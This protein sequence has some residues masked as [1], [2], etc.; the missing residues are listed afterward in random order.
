MDLNNHLD[1]RLKKMVLILGWMIITAGGLYALKLAGPAIRLVFQVLAPFLL[2]LL[3]AYL[4]YPIIRVAQQRLR[5]GRVG[6]ILT[7][8]LTL[9]VILLVFFGL[10]IPVLYS[11]GA[12]LVTVIE[13]VGPEVL[14]AAEKAVPALDLESKWKSLLE[15][16]RAMD[17][18]FAA[19]AERSAASMP[20]LTNQGMQAAEQVGAFL[21]GAVAAF[22]TL[23]LVIVI[24]FY[25]LAEFEA[26]P[27]I[28][29]LLTP[30]R[31]EE[32]IM[33]ILGKLDNA[34]A[35]FLRGQ[36]I[37]CS[38]IALS[39][40][41]GLALIGMRQY[42]VLVG[43]VAG[44]ANIIP[45]LGPVMGATPGVI[46]ALLSPGHVTWTSRLVHAGLVVVLFAI[47]QMLDGFVFQPKIVG[48]SSNLH[49]LLV[50]FA[51]LAG[52]QFGLGGMIL[53]VPLACVGRVLVLELWWKP[54]MEKREALLRQ[55]P[56]GDRKEAT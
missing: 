1:R 38:L 23:S 37:V 13:R 35:G 19:L 12:R 20:N 3:V 31:H 52:A 32:R 39:A 21:L 48:K 9:V 11:Q 54:Y 42:A 30:P 24:A 28:L 44:V 53:A 45:Y 40:S 2:A 5:I 29:R 14:S 22:G 6:G 15:K 33:D 36:L 41:I 34:L 25:Y 4:F 56:A 17:I 26:I 49:P 10:L 55:T 47:I 46:W 43:V 7:V 50:M 27:R 18:D 8:A 16:L 51:L